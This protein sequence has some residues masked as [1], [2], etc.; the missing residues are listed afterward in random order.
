MLLLVPKPVPHS[1]GL[2]YNSESL[3]CFLPALQLL[4]SSNDLGT[5]LDA[6]SVIGSLG[7][8]HLKLE[9]YTEASKFLSVEFVCLKIFMC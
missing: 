9:R 2:S 6:A 8:L 7:F 3:E 5:S 4:R 1:Q